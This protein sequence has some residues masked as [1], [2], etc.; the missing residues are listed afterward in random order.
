MAEI[1]NL[2]KA[3]PSQ[4]DFGVLLQDELRLSYPAFEQEVAN[5]IVKKYGT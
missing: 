4:P 3:L 5:Y 1:R 2:L